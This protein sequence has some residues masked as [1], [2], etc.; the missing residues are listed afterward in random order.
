[1]L[2]IVYFSFGLHS[3]R[4]VTTVSPGRA[5]KASPAQALMT[6]SS[7]IKLHV[8]STHLPDC[9]HGSDAFSAGR[10]VSHVVRRVD[11]GSAVSSPPANKYGHLQKVLASIPISS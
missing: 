7:L 5:E 3:Q 9:D 2:A 8:I 1:M 10:H 4:V 6:Q 11:G